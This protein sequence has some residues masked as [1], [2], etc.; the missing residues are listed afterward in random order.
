M[1]C[2][3]IWSLWAF[4]CHFTKAAFL[5]VFCTTKVSF[6]PVTG[7]I[8]LVVNHWA[9]IYVVQSHTASPFPF[10]V[11]YHS[12]D[13]LCLFGSP[14]QAK[15]NPTAHSLVLVIGAVA[16]REGVWQKYPVK[17]DNILQFKFR[18]PEKPTIHLN[19]YITHNRKRIETL[20]VC[21]WG[22]IHCYEG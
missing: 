1:R 8:S 10:G 3:I 13:V 7:A 9:D 20:S 22:Q 16:G 5:C 15:R 21:S 14:F 12:E 11:S 18:K 17:A 4:A 6:P 2:R 19:I